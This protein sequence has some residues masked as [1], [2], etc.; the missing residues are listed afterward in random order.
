MVEH[1]DEGRFITENV[2]V[3]DS[4][5]PGPLV[6]VGFVAFNTSQLVAKC[7]G[8]NSTGNVIERFLVFRKSNCIL[9]AQLMQDLEGSKVLGRRVLVTGLSEREYMSRIAPGPV[10]P[11]PHSPL[12][13]PL[14][15]PC[16][17]DPFA[18]DPLFCA[19]EDIMI[20]K[21]SCF[22]V[23]RFFSFVQSYF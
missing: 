14:S 7:L 22:H 2:L 10:L 19:D 3:H 9:P 21:S 1:V 11:F 12:P 20:T 23:S 5:W 15:F 8:R 6:V 17:L 18:Y 4:S 13:F 16:P